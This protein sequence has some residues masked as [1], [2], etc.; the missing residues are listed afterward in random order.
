MAAS[1]HFTLRLDAAAL[2][3]L[4]GQARRSGVTRSELARTLIEE[5]LRMAEHPGIVFREGAA[6]RRPAIA[7]G[8]QVWWI[9]SIFRQL[10]LEAADLVARTV[11]LTELP[12]HQV[13]VALRY[14]RAYPDEVNAWI[15][16]NNA[17]ADE[18][19]ADW[20]REQSLSA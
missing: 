7:G 5:G 18:G 2:D 12:P 11:K 19:Y 4:E 14:Y 6:G 13:G 1:R 15:D 3:H 8:P 17:L 9:A 16:R 10:G 20:V